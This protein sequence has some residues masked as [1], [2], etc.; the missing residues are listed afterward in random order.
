MAGTRRNPAQLMAQQAAQVPPPLDPRRLKAGSSE[1]RNWIVVA[2][3]ANELELSWASYTPAYRSAALTGTDADLDTVGV[4]NLPKVAAL[5]IAI[6]DAV[7]W[8]NGTHLVTKT[9]GGNTKIGV[10]VT[11]A[12]NPSATVDVRLNGAF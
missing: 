7:Y 10:A 5:A 8:D 1:I 3:A 2:A 6:G 12:A 9:A 11:V 4:F